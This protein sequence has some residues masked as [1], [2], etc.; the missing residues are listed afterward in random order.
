[1]KAYA[2][3]WLKV[4][5]KVVKE[6]VYTV[7]GLTENNEYS[8]RVAAENEAGIGPWTEP[9]LENVKAKDMYGEWSS[10]YFSRNSSIHCYC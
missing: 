1:M 7:D 6:L 10:D 8:F 5:K 2:T 9:P 3:K 4:N